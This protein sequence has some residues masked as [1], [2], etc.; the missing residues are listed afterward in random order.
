MS[1]LYIDLENKLKLESSVSARSRI[2]RREQ[3]AAQ[4]SGLNFLVIL[5]LFGTLMEHIYNLTKVRLRRFSSFSSL[6]H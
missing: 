2:A 3:A 4:V 5:E 6:F 1:N